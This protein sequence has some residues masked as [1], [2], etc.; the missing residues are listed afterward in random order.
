MA[1]EVPPTE[2]PTGKFSSRITAKR[3]VKVFKQVTRFYLRSGVTKAT[4]FCS[5]EE[6]TR[7]NCGHRS[8]GNEIV[9]LSSV[10]L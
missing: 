5:C 7:D 2:V 6:G 8:A 4:I 1:I 10:I 3:D 9:G